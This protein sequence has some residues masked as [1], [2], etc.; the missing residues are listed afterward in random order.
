MYTTI[1]LDVIRRTHEGSCALAQPVVK[2]K[3]RSRDAAA[4][5][6]A[7]LAAAGP[8][9]AEYGYEAT[10]V[11]QIARTASF[12][13]SLV[14]RY[15]GSKEGLFLRSG[16]NLEVGLSGAVADFGP[17]LAK[18]L[19]D[20]WEKQGH[21]DPVLML[22]RSASS[23][24]A[25]LAR[26]GEFLEREAIAP[27]TRALLALGLSAPDAIDRANAMQSFILGTGVTHRMLRTGAV[28]TA[29]HDDLRAWLGDVLQHLLGEVPQANPSGGRLPSFESDATA[30]RSVDSDKSHREVGA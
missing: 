19:V 7:L 15:F 25:A 9:F 18:H 4:T 3:R 27:A 16:L 30:V 10:T 8:R 20:R 22:L 1:H 6:R 12:S 17:Q 28:A 26:L 5:R 2:P 23:R 13:P 29:S 14:T 11:G 24:P 21:G